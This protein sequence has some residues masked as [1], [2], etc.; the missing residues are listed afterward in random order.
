MSSLA[1]FGRKDLTIS[2]PQFLGAVKSVSQTSYSSKILDL[3][4]VMVFGVSA[5]GTPT[6]S[7]AVR[8]SARLSKSGTTARERNEELETVLSYLR[9]LSVITIIKAL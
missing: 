3:I 7:L 9:F 2:K 4:A 6:A 5:F 8:S 1:R